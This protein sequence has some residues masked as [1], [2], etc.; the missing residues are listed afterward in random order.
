MR[1][2]AILRKPELAP[3]LVILFA[4]VCILTAILFLAPPE[5]GSN[6]VTFGKFALPD[7]CVFERLTGLPC[8]GCG[9]TRS[10][11]SVANG[12]IGQSFFHHKLGFVTVLYILLQFGFSLVVLIWPR[13][14][15]R[16]DNWGRR[17]NKGVVVL[18]ALFFV[19]WIVT[20]VSLI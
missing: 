7:V 9:L 2:L 13:K 10:M 14:K 3:Q 8:P 4:C 12:D 17:L 16:L 5:S 6:A 19:N 11:A 1:S 18:G 20:L 15:E